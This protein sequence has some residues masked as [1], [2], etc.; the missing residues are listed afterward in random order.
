MWVY[1]VS[2]SLGI[3]CMATFAAFPSTIMDS[4]TIGQVP[5]A[6]AP[7]LRRRP[8]AASGRLHNGGWKGGK[9]SHTTYPQRFTYNIHP[10]QVPVAGRLSCCCCLKTYFGDFRAYKSP[11]TIIF[12]HISYGSKRAKSRHG[13]QPPDRRL[14]R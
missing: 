9:H 14:Q 6:P 12:V 7:L 1:V 5:E 13:W 2:E 11:K 4:T 3:G 10:H 8:K